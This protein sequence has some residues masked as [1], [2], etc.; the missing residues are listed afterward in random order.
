MNEFRFIYARLILYERILKILSITERIKSTRL[1]SFPTESC[2]FITCPTQ[3]RPKL[4]Q[5]WLYNNIQIMNS[6][7]RKG[8]KVRCEILLGSS[9][10][11]LNDL[12]SN[13]CCP[14]PSSETHGPLVGAGTGKVEADDKK[15]RAKK[16]QVYSPSTH[17]RID[18]ILR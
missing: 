7:H 16:S 13:L 11:F 3:P 17:I 2:D 5:K 10:F 4:V 1:K 15:I 14:T 8:F 18:F 12:Y 9:R 6:I